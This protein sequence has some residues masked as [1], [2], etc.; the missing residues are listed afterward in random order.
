MRKLKI[1]AAITMLT[2]VLS[3]LSAWAEAKYSLK[4]I[5][6]DV[7][8]A[9]EARRARYNDLAALK[10]KGTIGENNRGYLEVLVPD[11]AAQALVE[12]ENKDR[13]TVYTAIAEQNGLTGQLETIEKVFA[14]VQR[15]KAKPGDKIQNPDG[16]WVARQ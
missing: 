2:V 4:E 8:T 7:N 6:P 16:Q 3:P 5:T 9:L 14:D 12:A 15:E 1:F 13:K 11:P 10:A